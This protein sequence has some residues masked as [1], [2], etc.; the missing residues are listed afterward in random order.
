[1]EERFDLVPADEH[2]ELV[3]W[4]EAC[5]ARADA[6]RAA[7]RPLTTPAPADAEQA[8][9]ALQR[10]AREALHEHAPVALPERASVATTWWCPD[11]GGLEAPQPC[12]G[13]C[14]WRPVEWVAAARYDEARAEAEVAGVQEAALRSL[15]RRAATVTP[16][17]GRWVASWTALADAAA[18]R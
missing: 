14:V 3:A 18:M 12:I 15:L 8:Y 4:A 5:D 11:C 7:V 2:D 16:R 10:A 6:L 17:A 1:V 13:I 9:R